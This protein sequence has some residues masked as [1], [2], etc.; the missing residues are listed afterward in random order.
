[1]AG[2]TDVISALWVIHYSGDD[3]GVPEQEHLQAKLGI[4]CLHPAIPAGSGV[5]FTGVQSSKVT[6]LEIA[7]LS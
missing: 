7:G 5:L 1:M 3:V 6:S 2:C 4:A